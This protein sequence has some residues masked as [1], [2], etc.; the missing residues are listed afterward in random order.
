MST[1][2]LHAKIDKIPPDKLEEVND[3]LDFII[4]KAQKKEKPKPVFGS[5]KGLITYMADDFDEPLE[6]FKDYM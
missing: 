2:L 1:S 5:G 6:D 4:Q 3:F